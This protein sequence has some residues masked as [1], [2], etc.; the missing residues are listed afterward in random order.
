MSDIGI[1]LDGV[2]A[3]FIF[4]AAAA[5][6]A[7]CGMVSLIVAFVRS[8]KNG[9]AVKRE[10]AFRYFLAAIPIIFVNLATF[11]ILLFFVDS[12]A[13]ETNKLAD[14]LAL[15]LWLPLQPLIWIVSGFTLN[16]LRTGK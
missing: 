1:N 13:D 4:L 9:R 7:V 6:L 10:K 14:S 8:S 12:N 16:R 3:F 11:G 5:A 15:Y 2:I